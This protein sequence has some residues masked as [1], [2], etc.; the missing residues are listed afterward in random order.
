VNIGP[1]HTLKHF[2]LSQKR[3]EVQ[4]SASVE[5][6][7]SAQISDSGRKA[8]L[9]GDMIRVSPGSEAS[10]KMMKALEFLPTEALERISE[11]G[12]KYEIYDKSANDLPLY[13]KKLNKANLAGAYSPT[14]NVVFVDQDNITAR[15][16]VHESLHALDSSLGEPSAQKPWT[17]ARDI[18]RSS[19]NA[20]R[21]YATHNSSEYFADNLA[22]SLFGKSQMTELLVHDYR[23][24]IGTE[25]LS[26]ED[27]VKTHVNYHREGQAQADPL[28]QKLCDKFW[29]VLPHYPKANPKPALSPDQYRAKLLE[30]HR[31][32]NSLVGSHQQDL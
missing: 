9:I 29:K 30:M 28:A 1:V 7:D 18:A 14:A 19:R 20:I 4:G 10:E 2:A 21:P 23:H 6:S 3:L 25:G 17:V 31:Q 11:Y 27:L 22:A 5:L 13:A 16:L 24:Q 15:I 26:K 12:T 8:A 32:R